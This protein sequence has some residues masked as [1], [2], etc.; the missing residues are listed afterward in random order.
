MCQRLGKNI[1]TLALLR[2]GLPIPDRQISR[3][4]EFAQLKHLLNSLAI[5]RV[6]DAGANQGQ[7]GIILRG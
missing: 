2:Y 3:I 1:L 5:N 6:I 4:Q 7:T